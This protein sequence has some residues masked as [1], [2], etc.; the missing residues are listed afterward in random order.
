MVYSYYCCFLKRLLQSYE[1]LFILQIHHIL[2]KQLPEII[3]GFFFYGT[4]IFNI[5]FLSHGKI[6]LVKYHS[7]MNIFQI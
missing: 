5:C 1:I 7:C 4:C 2:F 3:A 6:P